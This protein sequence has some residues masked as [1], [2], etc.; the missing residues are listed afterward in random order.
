VKRG[1]QVGMTLRHLGVM[2][3]SECIIGLQGASL[4]LPFPLLKVFASLRP[5][6]LASHL[7]HENLVRFAPPMASRYGSRQA[8]ASSENRPMSCYNQEKSWIRSSHNFLLQYR[9]ILSGEGTGVSSIL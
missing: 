7:C 8:Q 9:P 2:K 5:V 6:G 4:L 1:T 3:R